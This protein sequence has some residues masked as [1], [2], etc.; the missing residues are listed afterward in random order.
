MAKYDIK[1]ISPLFNDAF[2][3][4]DD[5]STKTNSGL[6]FFTSLISVTVTWLSISLT[7]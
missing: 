5:D 4:F 3:L 6:S 1:L 2:Y 7:N